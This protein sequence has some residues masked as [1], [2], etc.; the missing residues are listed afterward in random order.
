MTICEENC[1]VKSYDYTYKKVKCSCEIKIKIPIFDDIQFDKKELLKKFIDINNIGNLKIIK[2]IKDVFSKDFIT[3]NYGFFIFAFIYVSYFICLFSFCLKFYSTLINQIKEVSLALKMSYQNNNNINDDKNIEINSKINIKIKRKFKGKEKNRN[4]KIKIHSFPP[5]KKFKFKKSIKCE[6]VDHKESDLPIFL[7]NDILKFNENEL[8][9][10]KYEKAL[11]YDKRTFF[12]YYFSLLKK[13]HLVF[14]SFYFQKDYNP[15]IIKI[16]LFFFFFSVHFTTNALF[17]DDS[18]M[19]KIY[20]DDGKFNFLYQIPQIF[21]SS[22][23]SNLVNSLILYL[24]LSE[25]EIIDLKSERNNKNIDNK[26]NKTYKILK[27]KF[28]LFFIISFT[29]L[30]IFACYIICFCGVY[31]NTQIHLIK[32]TVYSFVLSL[33]YPFGTYLIPCLFR[34]IALQAKNKD[35]NYIYSFSQFIEDI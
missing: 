31:S 33:I 8:N 11:I 2:C 25:K 20:K 35:K 1:E 14:F 29:I 18:T 26:V 17:F 32:D 13:N 30:F 34:I 10:M 12:Q 28:I 5:K 21:Y 9:S 6:K 24:S 23:I 4:K 27:I 15:Q 19:H 16:F 7:N 3:N 22:L